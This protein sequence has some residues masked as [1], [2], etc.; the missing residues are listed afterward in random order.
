MAY[1]LTVGTE[2]RATAITAH[3]CVDGDGKAL[4]LPRWLTE[5]V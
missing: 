4:R 2:A 3:S 5:L 1:L